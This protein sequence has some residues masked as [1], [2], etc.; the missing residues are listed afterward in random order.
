MGKDGFC[1][2]LVTFA[3]RVP[4]RTDNSSEP[5]NPQTSAIATLLSTGRLVTEGGCFTTKPSREDR[6]RFFIPGS[7]KERGMLK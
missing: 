3:V 1:A 4:C 6:E 5:G 7:D 2:F